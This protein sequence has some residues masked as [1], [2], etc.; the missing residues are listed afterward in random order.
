[1]KYFTRTNIDPAGFGSLSESIGVK[2]FHFFFFTVWYIYAISSTF[3]LRKVGKNFLIK[4]KNMK[5]K[6]LGLSF[7]LIEM[8]V[9]KTI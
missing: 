1:M 6:H 8:K 9:M 5:N 7:Q 4:A 2:A 3:Y